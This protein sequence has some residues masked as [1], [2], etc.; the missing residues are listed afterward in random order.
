MPRDD[1]FHWLDVERIAEELDAAHPG[2]DPVRLT[3]PRLREL[4]E[5]LA[6]FAPVPGHPVNERILETIQ[7][8][9]LEERD[10]ARPERD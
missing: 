9:W 6:G 4:V 8:R 5:A 10:D 3:F 7:A 1:S 2:A